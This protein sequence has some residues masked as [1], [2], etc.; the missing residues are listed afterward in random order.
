MSGLTESDIEQMSAK[1][2]KQFLQERNVDSSGCLEKSEFVELAKKYMNVPAQAQAQSTPQPQASANAGGSYGNQQQGNDNSYYSPPPKSTPISEEMNFNDKKGKFNSF[3]PKGGKTGSRGKPLDPTYYDILEVPP[4]AEQSQI[5]KAYYKQAM[6]YHPDKNPTPEAEEKFKLVSEAYQVLM[7]EET[8][9]QYDKYGKEGL[10]P[11]GGFADPKAVFSVLFG[12][13]K[14]EDFIG[15]VGVANAFGAEDEQGVT[16]D[17]E[18][19]NEQN[20]RFL[21]KIYLNNFS[22]Q[23]FSN[24]Y[25]HHFALFEF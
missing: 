19:Q 24:K 23:Q 7:D 18:K 14:F 3:V 17:S 25:F 22:S 16:D 8:R 4:D 6:K 12:G 11:A 13:G 21:K 1:Q 20:E 15:T 5:K 2:L 10:E 9:E